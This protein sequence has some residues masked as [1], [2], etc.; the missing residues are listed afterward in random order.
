MTRILSHVKTIYILGVILAISGFTHLWNAVGF[1]DIFYDEGVY[2]ERAMHVLSGLGVQDRY[3]HDHPFFGQIFL[4]ASLGLVGFPNSLHPTT[5]PDSIAS[6]YL[7][8]RII[9]GLLAVVDTLLV[10]LIADAKY[11]KK[12]ALASSLLFAVMPFTWVM[13]R[14]LLDSILLPFLLSSILLALKTKDA[15]NK[16]LMVL[17]S[18]LCLGIAIFTK[19]PV[20]TMIPLVAGLVYFNTG[21]NAKML[22]LLMLPVVL[23]PLMW[24]LQAVE[25]HQFDIWIKDVIGQTQ[26]PSFGLPYISLV[27]FKLDPLLFILGITGTIFAIVRKDYFVLFWFMPFVIFLLLIG[28][29]QY[30]YW[31]PILPV[32][33]ISASMF[34]VNLLEHIKKKNKILPLGIILGIAVFGLVGTLLVISVNVTSTQFQ[35]ESFVLQNVSGNDTTILASPAYAW[36]LH[37]VFH[38][39]NVPNDYSF[40][41]YNQI[42]TGKILLVVDPHFLIDLNRGKK[43]QELYNDSKTI[44]TFDEDLSKYDISS[45][46]YSNIKMNLDG[47]HVEVKIK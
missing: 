5:D 40:I 30:F 32:F 13:R 3:F 47:T 2:M 15:K 26:R 43:L 24:P 21:K 20:F 4:A 12:I 8:P 36:I 29:N 9:M 39:E 7:V 27:F 45:Y 1:P 35:T 16:Y 28:Y 14:I 17:L 41:L 10:Y 44:T 6:L 33:C 31:I 38:K 23:I 34:I 19:I 42:H 11:G 25:A 37:Y 22:L 18:G 46:P